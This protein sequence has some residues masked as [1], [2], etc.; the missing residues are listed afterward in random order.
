M[1]DTHAHLTDSRFDKD[2]E[3]VILNSVEK[4]IKGIICVCSDLNHS[5]VFFHLLEKHPFIYGAAGIHPHDASNYKK[6]EK[7]LNECLTHRKIVALGE[8]GLD[9]YY[10]NSPRDIQRKVFRWQLEIAKNK[11][12][13][14]I[15]HTRE[16]MEETIFILEEEKINRG[17]MHCF[18]GDVQDMRHLV[19]MGFYISIAGPVTF[20]KASRLQKV[21]KLVPSDRLLTETDS[22]Y[23]APQPLRG[24]RNEPG[25]LKFIVEKIASLRKMP[26]EEVS[27]ITLEN[28]KNLFGIKPA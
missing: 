13:P 10:E 12:L 19:K 11:A 5:E 18:S 8:I 17:V 28:A 24:K 1:F 23:L 2:R 9:Y 25:F 20:P 7:K 3:E 27:R 15:I 6:L 4:G 16:A 14:V 21:A 22:P 26:V